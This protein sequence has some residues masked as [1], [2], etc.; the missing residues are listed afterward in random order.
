MDMKGLAVDQVILNEYPYPIAKCYE[1]VVGAKDYFERWEK[2][3]SLFEVIVKYLCC[4][5][6]AAYLK[7]NYNDLQINAAI[8][9]L[10]KPSL[11]HWYNIFSQTSRFLS[12]KNMSP[13]PNEMFDK[14]KDKE[15][16][17]AAQNRLNEFIE[18]GKKS[19]SSSTS[20]MHFL[21][22]FITY[23]NRTS[24]HGAVQNN[25]VEQFVPLLEKAAVDLLHHSEVLRQKQLLYLS[26]IK[27][28]RT[29]FMHT[30]F[31]LMGTTKVLLGDYIVNKESPF[32]GHDKQLFFGN[33]DSETP[34]ISL[35]PLVIYA[36]DE[37]FLVHNID[38]RQ[39][40]EFLCHHTGEIFS[41]ERIYEDIKE[42]L[43]QFVLGEEEGMAEPIEAEGIFAEVVRL[44]L[45]DGVINEEESTRIKEIAE[46]LSISE[47]RALE[48]QEKVIEELKQDITEEENSAQ[49][50]KPSKPARESIK[51]SPAS[52]LLLFPY[53]SVKFGFWADI[54]SRISYI[55]HKRGLVFSMV[56]PDPLYAYDSA[57][58]TALLADF[59][60]I[61]KSHEP[62][63]IVMAPPPGKA[64]LELFAN[65]LPRLNIPML[66]IDTEFYNYEIFEQ[67]KFPYPPVIQVDNFKGGQIA[68]SIITKN[69]KTSGNENINFIV[70][71]GIEEAYHS[72]ARA[73]GFT[74]FVKEKV[75]NVKI[76]FLQGGG[77]QRKKAKAIIA[78]FFE[79]ADIRKY[80]GIFCCNDEMALGV[81]S[82]FCELIKKGEKPDIK[83]VGFNNTLEMQTVLEN[84]LT[85]IMVGTV[86]Q[87]LD[88]YVETIFMV[89]QKLLKGE[90]VE[91]RYLIDPIPI[92]V[93]FT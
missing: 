67:H 47:T 29:N 44:S 79:D 41:A 72:Q 89:A 85:N 13:F 32:V 66:T 27:L 81:Y 21:E 55:A 9:Y 1:K 48:I 54:V 58:M 84:D 70:M 77:F 86:D 87:G 15:N 14:I 63:I 36:K 31:R 25:H 35:H 7:A 39:K 16:L 68:A 90:N 69:I 75:Q 11:G 2:L 18:P 52:R 62:D 5:N 74:S 42:T 53:A 78:D 64:F 49:L 56:A 34:A 12:V 33:L 6:L 80:K 60:N 22:T 73:H 30:F 8:K 4:I 59:D 51:Q 46:Q 40:V 45:V 20:L 91:R 24:G 88:N 28:E 61:L 65:V 93:P 19:T 92:Q 37:V 38:I 50:T 82:Y 76:K 17:I 23:R 26:E 43:G 57:Y 71:P 3:R 83:I 10:I